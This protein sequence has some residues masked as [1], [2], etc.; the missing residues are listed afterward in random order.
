MKAFF[1]KLFSTN[2]TDDTSLEIARLKKRKKKLESV[3]ST[4]QET[5]KELRII[6]EQGIDKL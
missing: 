1:K 3:L 2:K 6:K 5:E 4:L